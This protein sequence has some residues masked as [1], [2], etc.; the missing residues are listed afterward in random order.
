[1][2]NGQALVVPLENITKYPIFENFLLQGSQQSYK[3]IFINKEK[4]MLYNKFYHYY[5]NIFTMILR[6]LQNTLF[7]RTFYNQVLNNLTKICL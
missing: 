5:R 1:L 7:L 6:T 3:N 4:R 2:H